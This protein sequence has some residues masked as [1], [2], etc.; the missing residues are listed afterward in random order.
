MVLRTGD[1]KMAE[2]DT[3]STIR[4]P[5]FGRKAPKKNPSVEQ[6]VLQL[7]IEP[8][9]MSDV[10]NFMLLNLHNNTEN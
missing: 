6:I 4:K 8:L 9:P 2:S 3:A 7:F 10:L 5:Y 1:I